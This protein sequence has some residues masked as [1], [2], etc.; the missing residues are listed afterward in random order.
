MRGATIRSVTGRRRLSQNEKTTTLVLDRSVALVVFDFLSRN[1][2]EEDG[3]PLQE[4]FES[5]AE[6]PALWALLAALEENLSEPF[7]DDYRDCLKQAR[8]AVIEKF[9][10]A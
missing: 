5:E 8:A 9:G 2:D 10:G 4:A 7:S 3:E 1:A 6:L